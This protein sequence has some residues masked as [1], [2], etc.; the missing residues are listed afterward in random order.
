M[1]AGQAGVAGHLR[2]G[3]G[4]RVAAKS[5]VFE[6][7]PAGAQVAGIP[8][9]DA[10][11]WRRQ[12]ALLQRLED[13]QRR[14][15][16]LERRLG[17]PEARRAESE[18]SATNWD[19]QVDHV[20]AAAPLSDAARRPGA[21]DGARS[22]RIVAIK[23]VTI[24]E[25]FFVGHFPGHPVMP[26]VLLVEAMAQ[27]GGILLLHDDPDREKQAALLHGDRA[28]AV[29]ARPVVPGDQ[30]RFEVEVLRL[31]ESYV[32]ARRQGARRRRA[33]RA[34][35]TLSLGDGGPRRL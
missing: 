33:G 34:R 7:V 15:R 13:L 28:R 26:G 24:N 30:V 10:A 27:A 14:V 19:M 21:R 20:G 16:A 31:R 29:S 4:A 2:L 12:Q 18:M 11:K 17:R 1:L 35:P 5:A 6:D 8:A 3:E 23:N 25:E 22:K 32:Q 9:T